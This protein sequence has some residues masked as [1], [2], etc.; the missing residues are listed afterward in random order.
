MQVY[1][2]TEAIKKVAETHGIHLKQLSEDVSGHG[3]EIKKI[4]TEPEYEMGSRTPGLL[5]LLLM[6]LLCMLKTAT[7]S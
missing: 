5:L 6:V 4:S 3:T 1:Q 2:H 7:I